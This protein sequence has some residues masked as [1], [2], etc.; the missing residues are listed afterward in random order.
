[1]YSK[2]GDLQ[3]T[4]TAAD[5]TGDVDNK[6]ITSIVYNGS[7]GLPILHAYPGELN[8]IKFINNL[9]APTNLHFH[10]LYVSPTNNSDNFF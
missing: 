4:I 2:E 3:A 9:N 1:V 5:H 10:R 6:S 7:L 8:E